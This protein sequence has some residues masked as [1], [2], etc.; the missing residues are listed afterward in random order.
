MTEGNPHDTPLANDVVDKLP[1][2]DHIVTSK[3][4][5][6][7]DVSPPNITHP[8]H[9][10]WANRALEAYGEVFGAD[11]LTEALDSAFPC[12]MPKYGTLAKLQLDGM[13][14]LARGAF[15]YKAHTLGRRG[16]HLSGVGAKGSIEVVQRPEFPEHDFFSPGRKFE[17]RFRHANASF[18]DDAACVVR[19]ASLKFADSDYDSPFDLPMNSGGTAAFYNAR[20]FAQFVKA[21]QNSKPDKGD[22]RA[23]REMMKNPAVYLGT[24]ESVREAP[25]SYADIT[26]YSKVVFPFRAK[27]GLKRF[28]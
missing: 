15:S 12:P 2:V 7:G 1:I 11:A 4:S 25:D 9:A 18:T 23:Q 6:V 20:T 8:S 17:A 19:G 22:W 27:D 3:Q 13:I 10:H 5:E 21:R 14:A 28:C 26:Y 24:V 16:T